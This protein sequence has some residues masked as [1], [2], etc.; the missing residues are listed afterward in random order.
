MLAV[1]HFISLQSKPDHLDSVRKKEKGKKHTPQ[2]PQTQI[3]MLTSI[4]PILKLE[5]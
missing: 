5:Q 4:A 2:N 1:I 3:P